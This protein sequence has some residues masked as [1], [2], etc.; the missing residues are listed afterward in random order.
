V[1]DKRQSSRIDPNAPDR[2]RV[3]FVVIHDAGAHAH[4]NGDSSQ[5]AIAESAEFSTNDAGEVRE[6]RRAR[7]VR[8]LNFATVAFLAPSE[9][10][11]ETGLQQV[12]VRG[13]YFFALPFPAPYEKYFA[14]N[15]WETLVRSKFLPAKRLVKPD[16]RRRRNQLHG[17]R[18]RSRCTTCRVEVFSSANRD[19]NHAGGKET[20]AL[21]KVT[22][23]GLRLELQTRCDHD[24]S[25]RLISASK[26]RAGKDQGGDG[27]MNESHNRTAVDPRM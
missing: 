25:V 16:A 22:A 9:S 23:P 20:L 4:F 10:A 7:N 5:R 13:S 17:L 27:S 15:S 11:V 1:R 6:I 12:R 21:A 24:I 26:Q 2:S 18:R 3:I 8:R 14:E 19:L